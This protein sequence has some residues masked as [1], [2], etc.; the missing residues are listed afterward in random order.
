M[1]DGPCLVFVEVRSRKADALVSAVQSV[2]PSKQQR[3]IRT[4]RHFLMKHRDTSERPVRFDVVAI[5]GS[6]GDNEV[7]WLKDAFRP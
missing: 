3:L 6:D 2:N 7:D 1:S 5:S 4:G